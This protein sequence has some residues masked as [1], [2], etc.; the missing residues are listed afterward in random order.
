MALGAW[1]FRRLPRWRKR[2]AAWPWRAALGIAVLF[3]PALLTLLVPT[4]AARLSD[5]V[6]SWRALFLAV[7]DLLGCLALAAVLGM[8]PWAPPAR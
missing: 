3:A 4:P 5:R 2:R 6:F 7:P 1:R 8:A